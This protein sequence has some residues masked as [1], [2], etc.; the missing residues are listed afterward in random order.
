MAAIAESCKY[1]SRSGGSPFFAVGQTETLRKNLPTI[2][3]TPDSHGLNVAILN[4]DHG[5][6]IGVAVQVEGCL[7]AAM[8]ENALHCFR[9]LL[10]AWWLHRGHL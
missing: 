8:P 7:D 4:F 5:F 10:S 2:L 1:D 3:P 9:V 6:E